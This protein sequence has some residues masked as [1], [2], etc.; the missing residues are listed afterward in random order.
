M[1]AER[2]DMALQHRGLA[3][4]RERAKTLILAGRVTVNGK[5]AGKPA[6]LVEEIDLLTVTAA[7]DDFV[8]R[9]GLKLLKALKSFPI[10]LTGRTCMDIGA[11]TGGFTDCML[12]HGAKKVYAVDVGHDQ[13]AEVLRKDP[14][15]VNMEGTNVRTLTPVALPEL[16]TF[17]SV[18]VSFISLS[19]VL[20]VVQTLLPETGEAVCLVKPQ[21]E[22]GRGNVG[23]NGVV[24]SR[25]VHRAVLERIY[26]LAVSL[27]FAVASATVSPIKGPEGNIEYLYHLKKQGESLQRAELARLAGRFSPELEG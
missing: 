19:L 20:P 11:S 2:L 22:A 5:P 23:K 27:G 15:V 26:D 12:R 1:A 24:K 10:D 14:R 25:S 8:S 3:P 7:E 13:L 4:S 6:L 9:G 16:P 18:D 21:F 17:I